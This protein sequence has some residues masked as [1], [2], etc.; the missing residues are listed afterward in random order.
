MKGVFDHL[1]THTHTHI[2]RHMKVPNSVSQKEQ[3]D[4]IKCEGLG[5][6]VERWSEQGRRRGRSNCTVLC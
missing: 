6:P 1:N 4:T 3:M 5:S 2:R